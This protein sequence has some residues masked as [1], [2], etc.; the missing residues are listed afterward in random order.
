MLTTLRHSNSKRAAAAATLSRSTRR[1]LHSRRRAA[2]SDVST[3][4]GPNHRLC[5]TCVCRAFIVRRQQHARRRLQ[6]RNIH[7][8]HTWRHS[9]RSVL[10][11]SWT[12]CVSVSV[13]LLCL[14]ANADMQIPVEI[15]NE[16]IFLAPLIRFCFSKLTRSRR[17]LQDGSLHPSS[18]SFAMA[19]KS[20]DHFAEFLPRFQQVIFCLV[21]IFRI[22]CDNESVFFRR[23]KGCYCLCCD[24]V[25]TTKYLFVVVGWSQRSRVVSNRAARATAVCRLATRRSRRAGRFVSKR[26]RFISCFLFL[27]CFCFF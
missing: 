14:V 20:V 26:F 2:S 25:M 15:W 16:A 24:V 3:S 5:A 18:T 1:R 11:I 13:L 19:P 7:H 27:R 8:L 6:Q 23:L 4:V 21:L 9:R 10:R 22:V 17:R 12:S